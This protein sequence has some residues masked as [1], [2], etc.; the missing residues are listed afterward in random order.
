MVKK[1]LAISIRA[2]LKG[3][4]ALSLLRQTR[5]VALVLFILA[6]ALSF[7]VTFKVIQSDMFWAIFDE[8]SPEGL[9]RQKVSYLADEI[10]R[11]K[12]YEKDL[13][14]RTDI[15]NTVLGELKGLQRATGQTLTR[16]KD[17]NHNRTRTS[18]RKRLGL[19]GKDEDISKADA[20]RE[21]GKSTY[22]AMRRRGRADLIGQVD[23]HLALLQM[24][25]IGSPTSG[26]VSSGFGIRRSPFSR[27]L[28]MHSGLDISADWGTLIYATAPGNVT[29]VGWDGAYGYSV[30]VDHGKGVQTRY[31]H[32]S[33]SF[34]SE[35]SK[36]A[37]GAKI[38]SVGATGRTTGSHL[39]Y[40]V[41]MGG[42]PRDP[43]RLIELADALVKIM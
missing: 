7:A 18:W 42:L 11:V 24:L 19:G 2:G 32:L 26:E 3:L 9:Y 43:M 6:S 23:S 38:A 33:K 34:V 13:K 17:S 1:E 28:Q 12:N 4:I 20:Y 41:W 14:T 8:D 10:V 36:V 31:A 16:P 29:F 35:G 25:P 39:H 15:L 27:S 30:I 5:T 37:R 40:E 21:S 22:M